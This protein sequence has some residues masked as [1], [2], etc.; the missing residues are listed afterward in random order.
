MR[1]LIVTHVIHNQQAGKYSA[2][3]PYVREMN[4]WIKHAQQVI[5]VAPL[6]ESAINPIQVHYEHPEIKFIRIPALNFTSWPERLRSIGL[7]PVVIWRIFTAMRQA[8][9]IHLRCPGNIG[10]LGC[11]C[12]ILFP[13][14][15]KTAKYAGNWDWKSNQPWSYRL[16]QSILRHT[17]FTRKMTA[18]VYGLWP[19]K[20]RN[21]YPFFTAS[22][23]EKE[24]IETPARTLTQKQPTRFIF[25][26]TLTAN[27]QPMLVLKTIKLLSDLGYN[28]QLDFFG[29]GPERTD[30]QR[31]VQ[32]NNL[33]GYV[34]LHGNIA[35]HTLTVAY[36]QSH[37]LLFPSKS[38]GWPKAVAEAMFWGCL[39][40]TT[41]VSCVPQMLGNGSRGVL[42]PHADPAAIVQAIEQ[43]LN[44]PD[45]YAEQVAGA[46]A[47]SRQFTLDRF[48]HEIQH[49]L[50]NPK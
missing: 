35:H 29:E 33:E 2:Y 22:Y 39:P 24:V 48:E 42:I 26:G 37:F 8:D 9:H 6:V 4:I 5:I 30:L 38:E 12:Q 49:L 34:T 1:F 45:S 16:Q 3:G 15:S 23:R 32:E 20:T 41:P 10:L 40:V 27:K 18:L 36:R 43:Q 13:G 47:W 17:F 50:N 19:D 44:N 7:L 11:F 25:V 46:M 21:I 31:F 28:V 14:K